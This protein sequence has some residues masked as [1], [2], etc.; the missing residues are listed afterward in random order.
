[1]DPGAPIF[2]TF[3]VTERE[4]F[5]AVLRELAELLL[6]LGDLQSRVVLIGGQVLAVESRVR[7]GDG[8]INV[9]T[10]TGI[11]VLRGFSMEPDLLF[12]IDEETF[13]SERLPEVLKLRGYE[14]MRDFRWGK[15]LPEGNAGQ[16]VEIDLF[17]RPDVDESVLPTAMTEVPDAPLVLRQHA[18]IELTVAGLKVAIKVP[19]PVAFL[20]L[21]IR[22]K[23]EQ[24]PGETKDSFDIYAYVK[25]IGTKAVEASLDKVSEGPMIRDQLRK[26]FWDKTSPGVRDVLAYAGDLDPDERAL[27]AEDVVNVI[28]DVTGR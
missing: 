23:T 11:D 17:R 20:Q 10:E 24:R 15:P 28:H 13:E 14:R 27:L 6:D 26:L 9:R 22:A 25:M 2:R 8:V 21:K 3:R 5:E 18:R 16:R 4:Q 7:G 1:M 12:D 19:A